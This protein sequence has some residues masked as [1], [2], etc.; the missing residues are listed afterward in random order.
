MPSS[1]SL[2]ASYSSGSPASG[3]GSRHPPASSRFYPSI[4]GAVLFAIGPLLDRTP[5]GLSGG[6]RQRVALGRALSA[7]PTILCLDEPLSALDEDTREEMVG[8][9]RSVTRETGV[10]TRH[11]TH[12]KFEALSL[13]QR[14][15]RVEDGH[16]HDQSEMVRDTP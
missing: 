8:L 2:S 14:I 13:A 5:H 10:T 9:L 1:T 3:G 6:E 7:R 4:L 16:V 15:F 11:V 12:S